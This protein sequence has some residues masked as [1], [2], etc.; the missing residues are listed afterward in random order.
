MNPTIDLILAHRSIRQFTP[1]PITASQLD[2][3]LS[4]AQ[5]ASSSSF[6]QANSIIRVTDMALRARLAELAGHQAYVAEAAEFLMFCADYHRHGQIVP[7]AQ[8]GFVEQL[9]IGAIDGALMAQNALLAA[10]SLGLGG[11]YIGGIR[12]NPV[13][14]SEALGLPHQVIPL[15]GLCLGH[16]AQA[17]EQK[18]RL[19]RALVVHENHYQTELDRP[20]LAQYDQQI[21]A[22][23]Q[24]R[25]SNNK[26]QTWSSQIRGILGKE[27]RPFMQEFLQSKGF[28]LK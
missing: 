25:S 26:Q 13:A 8:T 21:E 28:N 11:V 24:A 1:E 23:Y 7:D 15:F 4:A 20:L 27:A 2:Q 17:P 10:Q 3:I 9:L 18:P 16:P 14:V 19:P 5:S 22:Y 6:L 12:N